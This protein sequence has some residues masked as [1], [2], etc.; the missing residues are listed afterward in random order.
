M[1]PF[2]E[3]VVATLADGTCRAMVEG[4]E[5]DVQ[6]ARPVLPVQGTSMTI[7]SGYEVEN[8]TVTPLNVHDIPLPAP[9]EWGQPPHIPGTPPAPHVG[10]DAAI[11]AQ[12][13]PY[14]D[15]ALA[16]W[17]ADRCGGDE[18]LLSV[19]LYPVRYVP[20]AG[21]LLAAE[22]L[23]VTVNLRPAAAL[24]PAP[25][26]RLARAL[27]VAHDIGL[28]SAP[29]HLSP[30]APCSYLVLST[31]N[32]ICN[33]AGPWNLQAL[34][35][36]RAR[37]GYAPA[38]V[39]VEWVADQYDGVDLPAKI[40]AFLQEAYARWRFRD[41][42]IV[43]TFELIPAR[44]LYV[45][46]ADILS[47]QTAEIPS[48]AI[49]YGCLDGP[50]DGNGNGRYGEITDGLNGGDVDLTAEVMVGR[51]PVATAE[52]LAHMVRKTLR[53]ETAAADELAPNAFLAEKVNFGSVVY[54]TGFMEELRWGTNTYGLASM[55]YEN[56]PYADAFDT[57]HTLYDSDLRLWNTQDAL[58][59]LNRDYLSVNHLGHGSATTCMKIPLSNTNY[60]AVV[61]AFTNSLPYFMYSQACDSGAFDTPDCFAE[62]MVTVSN[63]AFAAVMNAR[64]GWEYVNV[65]GG[66]SHRFHRSF[67][68]AALRGTATR[69]GTINDASRRA[70][71]HLLVPYAANYW[72]WVYYELNLFGDPAAPFAPALNVVPPV[73]TH[74]P[75]INTYDTQTA[76]RVT[77]TLEPLGLYDPDSVKLHWQ[78]ERAPG[79]IHTQHMS[80]VASNL[81]E[82]VIA[83]QPARTRVTYRLEA[84]NHA[85]YESG[86]PADIDSTSFH[87]TDRLNLEIRGSLFDIG[88]VSP[89]YGITYF[90]S[91]LVV[92]ASAPPIVPVTVSTRH[93]AT[94]FFGTGSAPQSGTNL[95]VTFPIATHSMLVWLW[96]RQ[97]RLTLTSA[98]PDFP[99]QQLWGVEDQA[100][101]VPAVPATLTRDGVRHV[102]TEWRLDGMR[103]PAAPAT[104]TPDYGPLVMDAPHTLEAIYLPEDLDAD[105]NGIAD[106]WE[107]RHTGSNGLDPAADDDLDGFT[108][109]E[110][111][112][113]R[114]SPIDGTSFPA[115]PVITHV[116]LDEIQ[117]RPG[118]FFVTAQITDTHAAVAA[119]EW[120]RRTDPWQITAMT[121]T[122][123]DLFTAAIADLSAPGDDIEYRIIATDPDGRNSAT[124]T[125]FFFL[126]YPVADTTRF[127]DLTLFALPTQAAFSAV[128]N[129]HNIGN[130]PLAWSLRF[131]RD[132]SVTAPHLPHWDW[133]SLGQSWQIS[134]NRSVSP[135]YALHCTL[136]SRRLP[137]TPERATLTLPPS[138]IGANAI[139]SFK[140]WI[141]SELESS[142]STRAF[143]GGIVEF[144]IDGGATFEQLRGPY[145]HTIY[146]WEASPWPDGTPCFA[147]NGTEGWRTVTFDLA[148][149]YPEQNGFAGRT[150]LFRFHYGGDNNTDNEGWYIDDLTLSPLLAHPAFAP[151]VA[152]NTRFNTSGG[153]FTRINWRTFP[154]GMMARDDAIRV[155]IDS[156]DPVMPHAHFDWSLAIRDLPRLTA[157]TAAQSTNGDGRVHLAAQVAD[158]D[159]E[160]VSLA[161]QW[162]GDGGAHWQPATLTHLTATFGPSLADVPDGTVSGLLTA[163]NRVC[164]TN[165]LFAAWPTHDVLPPPAVSTQALLR[166]TADNGYF[167]AA[168]TSSWFTVDNAPPVF[169]PGALAFAP[170]SAVGPYAV[171]DGD[172]TV[173]WPAAVD[174]PATNLTYQLTCGTA[175][176]AV[177]SVSATLSLTN[178]LDRDHIF[179]V[180]AIDPSGNRSQPLEATL[181]VLDAA[182]D[183]DA[184]GMT[185]ADEEIAGTDATS[186]TDRLAASL[187]RTPH[188]TFALTWA[189][190][191]GR[192][193]T[194]ETSPTLQPPAWQPLPGCIDMLGQ[195]APLTV[196]WPCDAPS[197][198]FRIRV[199]LP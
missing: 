116:P 160:P 105:G 2:A 79:V 140:H 150:L 7:P 73:L 127:H 137:N 82:S 183:T 80:Q 76:Y 10:P 171:T 181:L 135:P 22:A 132:E 45:S 99:A 109:A 68:D 122:S 164:V 190:A 38:I 12:A 112:A 129:L 13:T 31:S 197:A 187:A 19:A 100:L 199:R 198:F 49:Y 179:R 142:T 5:P 9:L 90:A 35:E 86:W 46:V 155:F 34:C 153:S 158:D 193:Y 139:F 48:D 114:T 51:F 65:V 119:V 170:L 97:H 28:Q 98:H 143:D 101:D 42:L 123:N 128:M 134:T 91:G 43:G 177:A 92:T 44:K 104:C 52:E 184:D 62:Q 106:W 25:P 108:C 180:I 3:P 18:S 145:T 32:L 174:L 83:P 63:A 77:C 186:P 175:T 131:A 87:V 152:I 39:S 102:F 6:T 37:S 72:R 4:C 168:F 161:V 113:D 149:L 57:T 194:V 70:N 53:H 66:Q 64:S 95:T 47:T 167:Q 173:S 178:A 61:A 59:H 130:A 33:T 21:R 165:A 69:L 125:F 89:D 93:V 166:V 56:S 50:F 148:A 163:T 14:P 15:P 192:L 1:I 55:G 88:T 30:D 196:E 20:A 17:R 133:R 189:G 156:N 159:G 195:G 146:G 81:F 16:P 136:V 27:N 138:L 118:P 169:L 8:V 120:R 121:P 111:F 24:P 141:H 103:S 96:Q 60:Q 185:A 74:T 182:G 144:S 124:E 191:A 94:G 126:Y 40:R 58:D 110:E 154:A 26:P 151:D 67:W 23:I 84:A 78:T 115:P 107:I 172:L 41:L 71:L 147:G 188:G 54:A 75:L 29:F 176:A 11:Y 157:F 162:S 117:T 36:A 85:G